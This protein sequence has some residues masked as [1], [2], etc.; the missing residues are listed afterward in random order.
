MSS[1]GF[2][3][4]THIFIWW[5]ENKKR[6]DKNLFNI[7]KNPKNTIILSAA[8]IWEIVIKRAK[9]K[10][11]TSITLEKGIKQSGFII[12]PIQMTHVLG[13]QKLPHYHAD[14]FDRLLISQSQ[15]ESLTLITSDQKIW[16]Y[17]ID[18]LKA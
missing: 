11:K 17:D 18:V 7:L 13:I 15:I 16:Q 4:D 3:L 6:L 9:G 12:L 10:L 1:K 5:M 8:T 2:L 14:P